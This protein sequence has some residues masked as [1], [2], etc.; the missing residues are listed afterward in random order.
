MWQPKWQPM[1][2]DPKITP[3]AARFRGLAP[4]LVFIA[5]LAWFVSLP[6]AHA[7]KPPTHVFSGVVNVDGDHP[8]NGTT[9][10]A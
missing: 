3:L 9:V 2:I 4:L 7:Q 10:T 6:V 1:W 8:P 5:A